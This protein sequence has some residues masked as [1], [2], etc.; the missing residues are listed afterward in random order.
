[1][2]SHTTWGVFCQWI[3]SPEQQQQKW[4]CLYIIAY[5]ICCLRLTMKIVVNS[6]HPLLLLFLPTIVIS[7]TSLKCFLP[8]TSLLCKLS[9]IISWA[10][11]M[12]SWLLLYL[13]FT[14]S[15]KWKDCGNLSAWAKSGRLQFLNKL[16]LQMAWI[17][18]AFTR[19]STK[20]QRKQ[21][22]GICFHI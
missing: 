3:E 2:N 15:Y 19:Q 5:Y 17:E 8:N 7:A 4:A 6:S 20:K 1:M 21:S 9:F 22:N 12:A 11:A 18:G 10:I 13:W 14:S 16:S